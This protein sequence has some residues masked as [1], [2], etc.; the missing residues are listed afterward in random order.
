MKK[1]IEGSDALTGGML[2][3]LNGI[4]TLLSGMGT[5]IPQ[6]DETVK[7]AKTAVEKMKAMADSLDSDTLNDFSGNMEEYAEKVSAYNVQ[8]QEYVAGVEQ[9]GEKITAL[10]EQ[11]AKTTDTESTRRDN[12]RRS[13]SR[14]D[15][16]KNNADT[17][18]AQADI[19]ENW[20]DNAGETTTD[21]TAIEEGLSGVKIIFQQQ[22][23][24]FRELIT[25]PWM[26][27]PQRQFRKPLA[28]SQQPE[29]RPME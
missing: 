6:T 23:T 21:M 12:I 15:T 7:S 26:K 27:E 25:V 8:M 2:K 28:L 11:I 3:Y 29:A 9:L 1:Y 19:I 10:R 4:Q 22:K 24:H 18:N 5:V 16:L 20:A 17:M 14:A 13:G